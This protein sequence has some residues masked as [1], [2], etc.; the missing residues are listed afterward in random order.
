VQHIPPVYLCENCGIDAGAQLGPNVVVGKDCLL[1]TGCT[2]TDSAVYAGSYVSQA[3]ELKDKILDKNLLI[4]AP[5]GAA[6]FVD[7]LTGDTQRAH[8]LGG[9]TGVLAWLIAL[10]WLL[11]ASPVLLL[12]ALCL[13]LFRRPVYHRREVVRLPAPAEKPRWR[14]FKLLSFSPD[15][16]PGIGIRCGFRSL[17]LRFLP[18]LVHIVKGELHFVG[19]PPRTREEIANL[20]KDWQTLYLRGKVGIITEASFAGPNPQEDELYAADAFYAATM[21][22]RYDLKL[23]LR[24]LVRSLFPFRRRQAVVDVEEGE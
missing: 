16:A 23:L 20:P 11:L 5:S 4:D 3:L 9:L 12:T 1:D 18:A 8:F 21:S 15:F 10:V 2:A 24:F 6:V 14:T 19:L 7:D 17:L 22:R 13:L